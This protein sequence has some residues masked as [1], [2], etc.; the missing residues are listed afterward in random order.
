MFARVEKSLIDH[1]F[2]LLWGGFAVLCAL[3]L[4]DLMGRME[5]D[6]KLPYAVTDLLINFRDVS[7]CPC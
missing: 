6:E 7:K 5:R 1:R 2:A 3:S 4:W